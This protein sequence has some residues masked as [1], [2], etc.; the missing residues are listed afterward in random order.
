MPE[1]YPEEI[2]NRL[3]RAGVFKADG[4]VNMETADRL[5]LTRLW[6]ERVEEA[7]K[8]RIESAQREP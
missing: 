4:A 8:A 1:G 2:R 6:A 5:G 3:I 7:A